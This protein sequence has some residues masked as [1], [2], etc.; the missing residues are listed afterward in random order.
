MTNLIKN[1]K[2]DLY[3]LSLYDK[4]ELEYVLTEENKLRQQEKLPLL[5]IDDIKNREVVI[6]KKDNSIDG[7]SITNLT[8]DDNKDVS[9][10]I[11]RLQQ[12]NKDDKFLNNELFE[13]AIFVAVEKVKLMKN[14]NNEI[15]KIISSSVMINGKKVDFNITDEYIKRN[16]GEKF[17]KEAVKQK[18]EEDEQFKKERQEVEDKVSANTFYNETGHRFHSNVDEKTNQLTVV[19]NDYDTL[20]LDERLV[21]LQQE[22]LGKDKNL[23][24]IYQEFE[25]EKIE[26]NLKDPDT[27]QHKEIRE[28]GEND[29]DLIT[30]ASIIDKKD[31]FKIDV[32][33]GIAFDKDNNRI[34]LADKKLE[35][36]KLGNNIEFL[37]SRGYSR[38]KIENV[39]NRDNVEW[40][41]LSAEDKE[42]IFELYGVIDNN[43]AK[44]NIE[45]RNIDVHNTQSL[46]PQVKRLVLKNNQ[47]AFA[48]YVIISFISGL[49]SG[50]FITLLLMFLRK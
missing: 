46:D 25:K 14:N 34:N 11:E 17:N 27:F 35:S 50:I 36:Q 19:S 29:K 30:A 4:N 2:V 9:V 15:P 48:S 5:T 32:E 23:N 18:I 37:A 8:F 10:L 26:T 1:E 12:N 45:E 13:A 40:K 28:L 43:I 7:Y 41:N 21:S 39:L 47:A 6:S 24:E 42:R 3:Y 16:L 20:S 22:N 44:E 33:N 38:E 31:E 49:S